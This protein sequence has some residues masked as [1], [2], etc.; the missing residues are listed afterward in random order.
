MLGVLG[1][2]EDAAHLITMGFRSEGDVILV[3]DGLS[4]DATEAKASERAA[5]ALREFSSSEYARTIAGI[6]GGAPPRIDLA[7]E[8]RLIN[9]LVALASEDLLA[10]AH[11]L[12]DGGLAVAL[13]ECCF[14]AHQNA[15]GGIFTLANRQNRLR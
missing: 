9:A 10:S 4:P 5:E 14:T 6:V 12:S 2:L 7:A 1:V 13:A 15:A 3:L 11:D 8:S